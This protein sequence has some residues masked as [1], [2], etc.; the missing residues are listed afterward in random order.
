MKTVDKEVAVI[1]GHHELRR[2]SIIPRN[3]PDAF[4]EAGL[5]LRLQEQVA[6]IHGRFKLAL[7]AEIVNMP[8]DLMGFCNL[9]STW[10][11]RGIF[12]PP[13]IVDP[14]FR[15][16]LVI[17]MVSFNEDLVV[18]QE[19]ERFLHLIVA[20]VSGAIPYC[21]QYQNQYIGEKE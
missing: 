7:T 10:A 18:I 11:R 6:L 12:I 1:L 19:G 4:R 8:V 13:T 20:K 9:R 2:E 14:G 21:G 16:R 5:D 3:T 17:E 15:G